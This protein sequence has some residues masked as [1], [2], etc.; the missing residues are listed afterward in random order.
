MSDADDLARRYLHSWQDYLT[1]LMAD[2]ET[3][4]YSEF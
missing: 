4:N 2:L 1:A 3:R